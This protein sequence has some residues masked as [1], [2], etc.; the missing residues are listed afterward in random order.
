M[1]LSLF[2]LL[3]VLLVACGN[4]QTAEASILKEHLLLSSLICIKCRNP[5]K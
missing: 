2:M 4:S 1:F 3:V 5:V